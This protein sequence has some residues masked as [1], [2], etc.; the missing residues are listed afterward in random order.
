MKYSKNIFKK[1]LWVLLACFVGYTF[2]FLWAQSQPKPD[3]YELLTPE[4]RTIQQI[5]I[6]TGTIEA[7]EIVDLKPQVTGTVSELRVKAGDYV[8]QGDII[9]VLKVIPD[10]S[11]L[12]NAQSNVE[13]ARITL[14]E[15]EREA[16]RSQALFEKGVISKEENESKQTEL[17]KAKETLIAAKYAVDVITKGSSKRSA[18]VNTTEVRTNMSGVVLNIPVK[19]GTSVSGSS[20]FSE[21]TT[22]AKVGNMSNLIFKGN[23]DE[24]A[25]DQL[26]IGMEAKVTIGAK[27]DETLM[28]TLEYI[29][30]EGTDQ[31]G[32]KVFEIRAG[33]K[34]PNGIKIRSGY[35]A[36]ADIVLAEVKDALAVDESAIVFEDQKPYVYQ[37]TSKESDEENQQFK[38]LPVELGIS[39]GLFVAIKSGVD[40]SMKLRGRKK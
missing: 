24:T 25:V 31:N 18:T 39:D 22:V 34:V 9:A 32:A 10:M 8:K 14:E 36:N 37:L 11:Q 20:Q 33:V 30:P 4:Q 21:G 23:I 26:R 1:A 38:R 19:V 15:T 6:A 7:R 27:P 5:C 28:A 12:N 17:A 40:K 3:I 16:R 13:S 29:A 2:Y 35:S